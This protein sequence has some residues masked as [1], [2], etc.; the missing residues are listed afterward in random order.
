MWSRKLVLLAG[1]AVFFVGSLAASLAQTA[2]QPIVFRATI[3]VGG[4]GLM[5]V[6][7]T[8]VSD[9]ITLRGKRE[10]SRH[11]GDIATLHR[12]VFDS[13]EC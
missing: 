12:G 5:T 7:R 6:A 1:L 13:R 3:L 4:G 2:V 8:I 9:V 11:L 10:I